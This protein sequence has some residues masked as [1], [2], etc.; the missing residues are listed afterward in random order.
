MEGRVEVQSRPASKM[1]GDSL[2]ILKA[3][4]FD[5][6]C[7]LRALPDEILSFILLTRHAL[8]LLI[9]FCYGDDNSLQMYVDATMSGHA[10]RE[11]VDLRCRHN[12]WHNRQ[13]WYVG[14]HDMAVKPGSYFQCHDCS[15]S[16]E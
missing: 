8:V 6:N 13:L 12:A 1:T 11:E 14:L 9:Q 10:L 7:K 5:A 2:L 16:H 15:L 3:F 4:R